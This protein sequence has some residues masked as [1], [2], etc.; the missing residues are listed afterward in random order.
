MRGAAAGG[1]GPPRTSDPSQQQQ[2]QQPPAP[3]R[4]RPGDGTSGDTAAAAGAALPPL[5]RGSSNA[6]AAA[7]AAAAAESAAAEGGAAAAEGGSSS[8]LADVV[9][10][11]RDIEGPLR[12]KAQ[13]LAG[14][15]LKVCCVCLCGLCFPYACV[16]VRMGFHAVHST[17]R[18]S[19][20]Q[21]APC[22]ARL[23]SW[24]A[25]CSRYVD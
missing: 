22:G 5:P 14:M 1:R 15:L 6:G 3:S 10:A 24:Q 2:Q 12:G 8:P 17:G 11:S 19:T 18:H 16:F 4:P 9:A 23:K 21:R 13:E 7:A 20:G 25:C